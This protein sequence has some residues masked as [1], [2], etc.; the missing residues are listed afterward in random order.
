M[1]L[2]QVEGGFIYDL[3]DFD[4]SEF[5]DFEHRLSEALAL[6]GAESSRAEHEMQELVKKN[7]HLELAYSRVMDTDFALES[8]RMVKHQ[9]L[10][11]SSSKMIAEAN[12]LTEIAKQVMGI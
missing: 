11:Q 1:F 2:L 7:E 12:R 4:M 3:E 9:I 8:T 6:N 5:K 10:T